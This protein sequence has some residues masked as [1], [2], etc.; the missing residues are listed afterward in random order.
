MLVAKPKKFDAVEIER[1]RALERGLGQVIVGFEP[2]LH[3]AILSAD[4]L[5]TLR[6]A[7]HELSAVLIALDPHSVKVVDGGRNEKDRL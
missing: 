2:E 4:D 1:I 7:E 6:A 5:A 3:A